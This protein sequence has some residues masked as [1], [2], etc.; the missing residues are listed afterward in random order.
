MNVLWAYSIQSK[1]R[2]QEEGVINIAEGGLKLQVQPLSLP[3]GL[4]VA[5]RA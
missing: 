4:G 1:C 2:L 3:V 5:T